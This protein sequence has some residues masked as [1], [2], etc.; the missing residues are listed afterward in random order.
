MESFEVI[1]G[2]PAETE[3]LGAAVGLLLPRGAFVALRGELA[4]GKTCFVRGVASVLSGDA[5]VSSPTFT[6]VNE[7]PGPVPV[8]HLDLYR[9]SCADEL[10]DLGDEELFEGE[11]ISLVEWA[12]R[13][14]SLL[15]ARRLEIHFEHAGGDQRRICLRNLGLLPSGWQDA[16]RL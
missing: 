16:L 9:L 7:Y 12:E 2:S 13:A 4:S 15:P 14:G 11:G 8:H 3:A 1:S 5:Q 10:A 6:L